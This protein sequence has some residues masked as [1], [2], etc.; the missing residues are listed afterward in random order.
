[1]VSEVS[2][3]PQRPLCG[4]RAHLNCPPKKNGKETQDEAFLLQAVGFP[5]PSGCAA[6][7]HGFSRCRTGTTLNAAAGGI[8]A[9][10]LVRATGLQAR[11]IFNSFVHTNEGEKNSTS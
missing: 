2:P 10:S 11:L 4:R 9:H 1:M 6:W 8:Q 5:R 3:S 7:K